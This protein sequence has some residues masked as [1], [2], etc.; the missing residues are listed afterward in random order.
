MKKEISIIIPTYNRFAKL[1][2]SLRHLYEQGI[3]HEK[4]EVIVIDDG[5]MD[6]TDKILKKWKNLWH[7]LRVFHQKNSG[8]A[9]ARNRGIEKAEG[10]II[11]LLQD[12]IYASSDFL[13]KHIDF[14]NT[15]DNLNMACLGLTDWWHEIEVSDFMHWLTHGGP[16]F[17][18]QDLKAGEIV[19][20]KYFYTSN[21]SLKSA[22][23]KENLFDEDFSDYGWEDIELGYRLMEKGLKLI[24]TP[25]ALA[26]HDHE[27][28][29]SDLKKRMISVGRGA[30]LLE[31]K[32]KNIAVIPRAW[33]YIALSLISHSFSLRI[34]KFL[35]PIHLLFKRAYWYS[36]SK[37]YFFEGVQSV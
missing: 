15:H 8:Q 22:I 21:I 14:H 6:A 26:W 11:L 20:Y 24:Y 12:D 16:Q 29:E 5:S 2:L 33:K 36:L 32:Q 18:Y 4:Y 19:S 7:E 10:D 1:D 9:K 35:S 23:L 30:V 27:M 37:R 17:A 31:K 25:S 13:K 3:S 34:L 28:N